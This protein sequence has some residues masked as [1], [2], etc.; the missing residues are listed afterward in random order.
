MLAGV[1]STAPAVSTTMRLPPVALPWRTVNVPFAPA[2]FTAESITTAPFV[3]DP[4]P[5]ATVN[6]P[7]VTPLPAERLIAPPVV[8]PAPAVAVIAPPVAGA[9]LASYAFNV[10][11]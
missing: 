7:P 11:A 3:V 1:T 2:E 8:E 10:S 9:A 6:A 4:P 5:L